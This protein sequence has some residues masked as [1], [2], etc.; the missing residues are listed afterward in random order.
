MSL[1]FIWTLISFIFSD[2]ELFKGVFDLKKGVFEETVLFVG[3]SSYLL[4]DGTEIVVGDFVS[5]EEFT[6]VFAFA[7][8]ASDG[9]R[10]FDRELVD[11]GCGPGVEA[12]TVE[13]LADHETALR[14]RLERV[15]RR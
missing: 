7:T 13:V 3:V 8:S 9:L 15:T 5:R 10:E 2:I 6:T 4:E 12:V 11:A 1:G 14:L